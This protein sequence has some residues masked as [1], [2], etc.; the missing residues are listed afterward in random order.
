MSRSPL[1]RVA[2]LA[3]YAATEV[4][5]GPTQAQTLSALL[6][7]SHA[8]RG[9]SPDAVNARVNLCTLIEAVA[10]NELLGADLLDRASAWLCRYAYDDSD[11]VARAVSLALC[12]LGVPEP[13]TL[14]AKA[15]CGGVLGVD[16]D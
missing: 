6:D 14:G 12:R 4:R 8:F 15:N 2:R 5:D 1:Y 3:T 9:P 11:E 16:R 13:E 10:V 7:A